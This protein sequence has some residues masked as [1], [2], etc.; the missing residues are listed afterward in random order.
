MMHYLTI[1]KDTKRV[2]EKAENVIRLW[3]NSLVQDKKL[4]IQ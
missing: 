2:Y 1:R 4:Q 3:P